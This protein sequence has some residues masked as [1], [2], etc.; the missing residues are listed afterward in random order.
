MSREHLGNHLVSTSAYITLLHCTNVHSEYPMLARCSISGHLEA[1]AIDLSL[2]P[3]LSANYNW[4][5]HFPSFLTMVYA[6]RLPWTA[7][8]LRLWNPLDQWKVL[9]EATML[10]GTFGL[11][12]TCSC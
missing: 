2:A 11:P 9:L 8:N 1:L 7:T 12:T 5:D 10:V 3:Q 4:P 6:V